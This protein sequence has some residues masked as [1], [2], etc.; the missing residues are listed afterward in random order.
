MG[1]NWADD[2][3]RIGQGGE[4]GNEDQEVKNDGEAGLSRWTGPY[5]SVTA[6]GWYRERR[7]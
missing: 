7:R 5:R 6:D 2:M 1:K 3:A 4:M